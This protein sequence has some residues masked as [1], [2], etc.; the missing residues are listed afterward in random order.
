ML[1]MKQH[2]RKSW[3][4]CL[5]YQ[6]GSFFGFWSRQLALNGHGYFKTKG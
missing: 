6:R 5:T 2:E 3:S 4:R 1:D